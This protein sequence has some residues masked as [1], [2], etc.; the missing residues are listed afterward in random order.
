MVCA[1]L[2]ELGPTGTVHMCV[3]VQESWTSNSTA[4]VSA[5]ENN[6][7]ESLDLG[8]RKTNQEVRN[9]IEDS[10]LLLLN[11]RVEVLIELL[12]SWVK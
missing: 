9:L 11:E 12:G 3:G 7:K 6:V 10:N 2:A 8:N 1:L 5:T 4:N